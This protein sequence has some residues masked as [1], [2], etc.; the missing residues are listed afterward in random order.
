MDK[1]QEILIG[2][3]TAVIDAIRIIDKTAAQICVVVDQNSR[4]LGTVTDGDIRRSILG[5]GALTDSVS[6]IMNKA[7]FSASAKKD[8]EG[9]LEIMQGNHIH[10]IPV[11]NDEGEVIGIETIDNLLTLN[12]KADNWVVLM[13][14]GLGTRLRPLT[15]NT[16]KPLLEVGGKPLI[17]TIVE[18]ASKQGFHRFYIAVNYLAESIKNRLGDGSQWNTEIFYLEEPEPLGTAGALSLIPTPPLEPIIVMNGDLL[19]K[20]NLGQLLSYHNSH[21]GVMTVGVREYDFQVPYGVV[22]VDDGW[23]KYIDEKPI[24]RTFVNAGIYIINP[25]VLNTLDHSGRID[26]PDLI[27]TLQSNGEKISA[28]PIIE[29]WM[30]I[31]SP[32]D[33]ERANKEFYE[34]FS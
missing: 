16:P 26:M 20:I 2:P 9:L 5:G 27:S 12:E 6:G 19:T 33:L 31:G 34:E 22:S 30:D 4:L 1:W 15:N 23:I 8:P 3:A 24:H 25:E 29:Y 21:N 32:K 13:A 10:Q 28:F 17:E 18:K 7:P 11:L 14:G